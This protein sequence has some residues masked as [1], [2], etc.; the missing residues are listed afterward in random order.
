MLMPFIH[1]LPIAWIK[2]SCTLS[3]RTSR[4][5]QTSVL[6]FFFSSSMSLATCFSQDDSLQ[7]TFVLSKGGRKKY[8]T[9][10]AFNRSG[11]YSAY[12]QSIYLTELERNFI[13]KLKFWVCGQHFS[14]TCWELAAYANLKRLHR[15]CQPRTMTLPSLASFLFSGLA[16][17][18]IY[19]LA[20]PHLKYSR[21]IQNQEW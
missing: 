11:S 6:S 8:I 4:V 10:P 2:W 7:F 3:T 15:M 17:K 13:N 5:G 21:A 14:L 20:L 18:K 12:L 9:F 16:R 19:F 1:I